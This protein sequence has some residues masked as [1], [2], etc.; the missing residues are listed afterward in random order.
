MTSTLSSPAP[1]TVGLRSTGLLGDVHMSDWLHDGLNDRDDDL[2]RVD[3]DALQK[4]RSHSSSPGTSDS[5]ATLPKFGRPRITEDELQ[6]PRDTDR[7]SSDFPIIEE[8]SAVVASLDIMFPGASAVNHGQ[9]EENHSDADR[10]PSLEERLPSS[11]PIELIRLRSPIAEP[12][13]HIYQYED[14]LGRSRLQTSE[15]QVRIKDELE[16][17]AMDQCLELAPLKK[18]FCDSNQSIIQLPPLWDHLR[19]GSSRSATTN[20]ISTSSTNFS[21]VNSPISCYAS[22]GGMSPICSPRVGNLNRALTGGAN[23]FEG[24]QQIIHRAPVPQRAITFPQLARS[25]SGGSVGSPETAQAQISPSGSS[26]IESHTPQSQATL[27]DDAMSEGSSSLSR[28]N[29]GHDEELLGQNTGFRCKHDG[30]TA[31]PFATQYLLKCVP[32]L[33]NHAPTL[34]ST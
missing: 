21:F 33:P 1:Q 6:S 25:N 8:E 27:D 14:E 2:P 20:S 34:S 4:H 17:L 12:K 18:T 10:L 31:A 13:G 19:Q 26:T 3:G 28:Q 9:T 30:C 7:C 32:G 16:P 22:P 23:R 24:L 29:S 5:E 15:P 11:R